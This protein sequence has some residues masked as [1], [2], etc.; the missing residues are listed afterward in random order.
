MAT[1]VSRPPEYA[2]MTLSISA[3]S[4]A[5][6]CRTGAWRNKWSVGGGASKIGTHDFRIGGHASAW[7]VH[8]DAPVLDYVGPVGHAQ[9]HRRHLLDEQD[10]DALGVQLLDGLGDLLHQQ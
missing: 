7:T 2:R 10:G 8:H 3:S 4:R 6:G 9:R 1:D 5:E